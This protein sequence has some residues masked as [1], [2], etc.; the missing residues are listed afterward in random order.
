MVRMLL[1]A[2]ATLSATPTMAQVSKERLCKAIAD[3]PSIAVPPRDRA[4]FEDHCFCG[5]DHCKYFRVTRALQEFRLARAERL[6]EVVRCQFE[7]RNAVAEEM[8]LELT[9]D[10]Y[11]KD[12][13]L[14]LQVLQ[15]CGERRS[16]QGVMTELRQRRRETEKRLPGI[17]TRIVDACRAFEACMDS[18]DENEETCL[19]PGGLRQTYVAACDEFKALIGTEPMLD[20]ACS[21]VA[22]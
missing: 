10:G 2:M 4:F 15:L 22:P 12:E 9:S 14:A 16:A 21:W 19:G 8:G 18:S 17:R 11:L 6:M 20:E 5:E 1:V 3:T 13:H 7:V